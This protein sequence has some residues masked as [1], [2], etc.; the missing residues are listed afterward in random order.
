MKITDACRASNELTIE[1]W[2][3]PSVGIQG[4]TMTSGPARIVT[5][6]R[7]MWEPA[8]FTMGQWVGRLHVRLPMPDRPLGRTT[9][10][11]R[12]RS[13]HT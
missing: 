3:R 11:T 5:L 1:A 8:N 7:S 2:I 10:A 12:P 4:A 13:I 6:S 9:L